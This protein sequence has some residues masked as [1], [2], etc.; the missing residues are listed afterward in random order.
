VPAAGDVKLGDFGV[1]KLLEVTGELAHTR[2]SVGGR[3]PSGCGCPRPAQQRIAAA[4][5]ALPRLRMPGLQLCGHASCPPARLPAGRPAGHA[6]VGTPYTM[7]P[8]LCES[9]GYSA[10]SDVWALG[11]VIYECCQLRPPF[12][13]GNLGARACGRPA[14][15][16]AATAAVCFCALR[17]VGEALRSKRLADMG[18]AA[19]GVWVGCMRARSRPQ[20]RA[21]CLFPARWQPILGA[22]AG[23]GEGH[24]PLARRWQ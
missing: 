12:D 3:W 23:V 21:R 4:P 8:E 2:V 1:S 18:V 15:H 6:Q 14:A 17:F 16:A 24:I 11:C 20:D 22:A 13:A 9:V 10:K 5:T 19:D 7:S